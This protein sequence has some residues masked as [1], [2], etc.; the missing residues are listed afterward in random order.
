MSHRNLTVRSAL[1][2]GAAT[3]AAL[4]LSPSY[5]ADQV[6]QI[7]VTGTHIVS[8]NMQSAS[9]V[10]EASAVD[11]QVQGVTKIEDLLNQLPQVFAGQSA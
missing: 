1:F 11:I 4:T 9:P 10:L 8:P 5:A 2:L 6:E 3:A 7:V